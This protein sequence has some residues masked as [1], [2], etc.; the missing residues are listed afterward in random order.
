M[1]SWVSGNNESFLFSEDLHDVVFEFEDG[2]K[3]E[4]SFS[5]GVWDIGYCRSTIERSELGFGRIPL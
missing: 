1:A 5:E 2:E 3:S 4:V